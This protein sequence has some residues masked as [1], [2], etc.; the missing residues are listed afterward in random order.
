MKIRERIVKI[1]SRVLDFVMPRLCLS[2][3]EPVGYFE[4]DAFCPECAE[5]YRAM[6][7]AVCPKCGQSVRYCGCSPYRFRDFTVRGFAALGF[8]FGFDDIVGQ[9]VYRFKRTNDRDLREY[10][11]DALADEIRRRYPRNVTD[12]VIVYPPRSD[13]AKRRYGFDQSALLAKKVASKLGCGCSDAIRRIGGAEQKRLNAAE[14]AENA[15]TE[16]AIK[17]ADAVLGRDVIV[18]DDVSTTGS[19]MCA[20]ARI[21]RDAGA[22]SVF[23]AVLFVTPG[24]REL[25][26]SDGLWFEESDGIGLENTDDASEN[27][28]FEQDFDGIDFGF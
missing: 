25:P 15:V 21:V 1:P 27:A 26:G 6:L 9:T 18:I 14:R 28:G 23:P 2:C 8:Y 22:R 10:F 17:D 11:A 20:A 7:D 19:T 16:F 3:G 24:K 4:S 12:A 13:K 5:K